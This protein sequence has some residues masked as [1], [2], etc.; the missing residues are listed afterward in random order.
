[1]GGK[2]PPGKARRTGT[3]VGADSERL[4]DATVAALS[5]AKGADIRTLDVRR[6]TDITDYMVVA[7][8]ASERHIKTLAERVLDDTRAAGWRHLGVEGLDAPTADWVLVDLADVVVHIMR[9]QTREHYDLESL[10]D[11]TLSAALR[12][13]GDDGVSVV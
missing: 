3:G 4:R 8:G 9:A 10:W 1:M 11:D 5:D 6:L 2:T 12:G 7:T 13:R